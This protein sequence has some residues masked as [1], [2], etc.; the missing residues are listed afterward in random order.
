MRTSKPYFS[1]AHSLGSADNTTIADYL[2]HIGSRKKAEELLQGGAS[3]NW[4]GSNSNKPWQATGMVVGYI[5][6][7]QTGNQVPVTSAAAMTGDRALISTRIKIS[8]DRFFVKEYPGSGTHKIL[9]EFAG[10]NQVIS[11]PRAGK[12]SKDAE[13]MRFA[14]NT[15]ANDNE[16]ASVSGHPIFLGVVVGSDGLSF[17]GRTVNVGSK[18]NDAVQ[19]ML[20][21]PIFKNGLSL[22]T[23]AQPALKPFVGLAGSVVEAVAKS[24][25]NY[26]V[27]N[28]NLGLDFSENITSAKLRHG[29]YVIIQ[30]N[31]TDW[32]W[33]NT[34]WSPDA[35]CL[36][37][38]QTG[39]SVEANYLILG[40]SPFSEEE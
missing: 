1:P 27:H 15:Q 5:P 23:S 10:K 37:D 13:E 11:S 2:Q 12:K 28:F 17:E 26:Q 21:S 14:F 22:M 6:P 33:T 25:D 7:R 3:G 29:S 4:F 18:M 19:K 40:V 16:P 35:L 38:N 20:G 39:K 30:T 34:H 31:Q 8:L 24:K 36:I 32:N 9:C